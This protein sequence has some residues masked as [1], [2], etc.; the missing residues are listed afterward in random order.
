[1]INKIAK[2]MKSIDNNGKRRRPMLLKYI[3]EIKE[4]REKHQCSYEQIRE[5]L[6]E[7][8]KIK[9]SIETI[10]LFYNKH[11]NNCNNMDIDD[12]SQTKQKEV[13]NI[14][15]EKQTKDKVNPTKT[16]AI[17]ISEKRKEEVEEMMKK[18]WG[19]GWDIKTK[20]S[21]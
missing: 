13:E 4:L 6:L 14:E 17:E 18:T 11:C 16:T 10:R 12:I 21:E 5:Y 19:L 9:V 8:E 20:N 3:Y 7:I 2:Y 15:Q 1:M